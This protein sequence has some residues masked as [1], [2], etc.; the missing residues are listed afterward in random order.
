MTDRDALWAAVLAAPADDAPRLVY[1]DWLDEHGEPV[2]AEFIRVQCKLARLPGP[3]VPLECQE[4]RRPL[5]GQAEPV[6]QAWVTLGDRPT[7]EVGERITLVPT[8]ATDPPVPDLVVTDV[9]FYPLPGDR[10]APRA[11]I[12]VTAVPAGPAHAR[13]AELTVAE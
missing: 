8:D 10:P 9:P 5:L 11:E 2:L 6:Y 12:R 4:L 3:A 13:W 1:A 7:P